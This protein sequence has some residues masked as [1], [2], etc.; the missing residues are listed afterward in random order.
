MPM[1]K[2]TKILSGLGA[3]STLAAATDFFFCRTLFN[4]TLNR[5]KIKK[6]EPFGNPEHQ[7]NERQ[8]A[9]H[10]REYLCYKRWIENIEV[11]KLSLKNRK[12]IQ[13]IA[14]IYPN[15]ET[16]HKWI[17]LLHGYM[18][19][20][21]NMR[22]HA[23]RF[24]EDGYHVLVPDLQSHGESEGAYITLGW[25][26]RL[27]TKEW[28][29]SILRVDS[30]AEIV[31]YGTSMGA[32]IAMMCAGEE[33]SNNVK[34]VIEDS[35]YTS[36]YDILAHMI[37][38]VYK[39]PPFPI[40]NSLGVLIRQRLGFSIKKASALKQLSKTSLPVMFIHGRN[41][42]LVPTDMAFKLYDS[43][44]T[45]KRLYIV[46]DCKH[47][48]TMLTNPNEYFH[49]VFDFINQYIHDKKS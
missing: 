21:E 9:N 26:D 22:L 16:S 48:V 17:I 5:A 29:Q 27:D 37:T 6:K 1:N 41:D 20:K 39:I 32:S 30:E 43:C 8:I 2:K 18:E 23:R 12:G 3:I 33:L 36:A 4:Q 13:L 31:L 35:G 44:P 10:H 49:N 46:D 34:C 25:S 42:T 38:Y 47:T 7:M 28:I 11:S 15:E 14:N 40:I 45:E 24:H 19:K